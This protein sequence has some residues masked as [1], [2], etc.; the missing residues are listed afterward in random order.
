MTEQKKVSDLKFPR[1]PLYPKISALPSSYHITDQTE[2]PNDLRTALER[3]VSGWGAFQTKGDKPLACNFFPGANG[4]ILAHKVACAARVCQMAYEEV[5]QHSLFHKTPP[6]YT[7]AKNKTGTKGYAVL[8]PWINEM[9]NGLFDRLPYYFKRSFIYAGVGEAIYTRLPAPTLVTQQNI[10]VPSDE[11]LIPSHTAEPVFYDFDEWGLS[12]GVPEK[13]D[14]LLKKFLAENNVNYVET[15][16]VSIHEKRFI[17]IELLEYIPEILKHGDETPFYI[18]A[19]EEFLIPIIKY[20]QT[21][22]GSEIEDMSLTVEQ[23]N[24]FAKKDLS[25]NQYRYLKEN[26]GIIEAWNIKIKENHGAYQAWVPMV[27]GRPDL[28]IG[29]II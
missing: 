26:I 4:L 29:L 22:A 21:I 18:N 9:P 13:T 24:F 2:L 14:I 8:I 20:C 17:G 3:I 27:S 6:I 10:Y 19:S 11:K 16:T 5:I 12:A 1:H 25:K 15:E 28:L 23:N 7:P